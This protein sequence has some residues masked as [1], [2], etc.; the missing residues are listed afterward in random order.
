MEMPVK[1]FTYS[2]C[3]V[4]LY[5]DWM[6]RGSIP[7]MFLMTTFHVRVVKVLQDKSAA[8]LEVNRLNEQ[9][10]SCTVYFV[11]RAKN[12]MGDEGCS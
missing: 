11:S 3:I 5:T 4:R 9:A 10:P 7:S 8:S 2:Y 6:E 1:K 12:V